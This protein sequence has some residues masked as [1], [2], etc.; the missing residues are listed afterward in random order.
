MEGQTAA[1][2]SALAN[3]SGGRFG[4]AS[5]AASSPWVTPPPSR[6]DRSERAGTGPA[7]VTKLPRYRYRAGWSAFGPHAIGV[8][9]FAAVSNG[10]SFAQVVGAILQKQA[11][12]ENPD[13]DE[14]LR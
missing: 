4:R 10:P 5:L 13:K 6:F 2:T 14:A 12:V 7:P 11:R 9:R 1:L 8:E 3:E